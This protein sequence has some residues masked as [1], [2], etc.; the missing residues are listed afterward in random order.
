M[1]DSYLNMLAATAYF[2]DMSADDFRKDEFGEDGIRRSGEV[3]ESR[4]RIG[5]KTTLQALGIFE[6]ARFVRSS[7]SGLSYSDFLAK[8]ALHY[9]NVIFRIKGAPDGLPIPPWRLR[10]LTWPDFADLRVYF[11]SE[12]YHAQQLLN[13]L[14]QHGVDRLEAML[15]FGCGTGRVLRQ[16]HFL[17]MPPKRARLYGTDINAEQIDWCRSHLPFAEFEVNNPLPPLKYGDETFV[18]IYNFSVFTHLPEPQQILWI[19]ELSRVLRPGGYLLITTCGESYLDQ[20]TEGERERFAA[21]HL[22]VRGAE[23]AGSPS[24][25]IGCEAY[26]PASYV[27]E[28]LARGFEVIEFNTGDKSE[29]GNMD[30][31]L[32]RK[33]GE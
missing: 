31:Y 26:H 5:G 9:Y 14:G 16:F 17:L 24:A 11:G 13:V 8:L 23:S 29:R 1:D 4:L 6:T 7:L 20:L 30:R 2:C 10:T 3:K 15:G 12:Q 18:F 25:Y 27:T 33:F 22:I 21:G 32:L 28:K 19:N